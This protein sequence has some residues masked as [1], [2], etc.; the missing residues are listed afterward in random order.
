MAKQTEKQVSVS[1]PHLCAHSWNS[2]HINVNQM[3]YLFSHTH[4]AIYQSYATHSARGTQRQFAARI[5]VD[6]TPCKKNHGCESDAMQK[7]LTRHAALSITKPRFTVLSG[8][9][10]LHLVLHD[11]GLPNRNPGTKNH[12]SA[13]NEHCEGT[14]AQHRCKAS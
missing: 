14:K 7:P 3:H 13:A 6:N 5:F 8:V 12:S 4:T 11:D 1:T 10:R 2:S 9:Q